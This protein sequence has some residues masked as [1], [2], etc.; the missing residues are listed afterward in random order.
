MKGYTVRFSI[1]GVWNQSDPFRS[2][3]AAWD[4][5][6]HVGRYGGMEIGGVTEVEVA[7]E[8]HFADS[9]RYG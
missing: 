1:N 4:Y 5:A 9:G 3:D 7:R 8:S 2:E 6:E